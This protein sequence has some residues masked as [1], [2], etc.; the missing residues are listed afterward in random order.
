MSKTPS[1]LAALSAD[2]LRSTIPSH[3]TAGMPRQSKR[4]RARPARKAQKASRAKP[5]RQAPLPS[6]QDLVIQMLRRQ[7]GVT[8]KEIVAK[9][10]WQAHSVRGFFSGV[11]KK[12]LKLALTSNVGKDGVRRYHITTVGSPKT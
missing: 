1:S 9:T 12:K 11:V 6:K 7:T 2:E 3:A 4:T 5:K 10:G 8:I